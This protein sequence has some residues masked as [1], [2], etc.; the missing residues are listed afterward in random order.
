MFANIRT[1]VQL[2]Q[3]LNRFATGRKIGY[4]SSLHQK[5][6]KITAMMLTFEKDKRPSFAE[7]L[8]EFDK[9]RPEI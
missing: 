5:W 2:I 3:E 1:K 6:E 9:I 8:T 4:P 7:V